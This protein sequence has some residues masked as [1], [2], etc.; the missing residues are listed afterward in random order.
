MH[1]NFDAIIN[2][3]TVKAA[4]CYHLM[5]SHFPFLFT[6]DYWIKITGVSYHSVNVT[7]YGLAHIDHINRLLLDFQ[8]A[9]HLNKQFQTWQAATWFYFIL[10]I[11]IYMSQ[12]FAEIRHFQKY[13]GFPQ[14]PRHLQ[15]MLYIWQCSNSGKWHS[16]SKKTTSKQNRLS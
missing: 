3:T 10:D 4:W 8:N 5:W 16:I 11:T 6:K 9:I 2:S 13:L 15:K 7:T 14:L 1:C 12:A